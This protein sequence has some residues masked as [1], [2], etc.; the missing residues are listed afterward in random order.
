MDD[1]T[2]FSKN[3]IFITAEGGREMPVVTRTFKYHYLEESLTSTVK[4]VKFH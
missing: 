1:K 4:I 3:E 2:Q